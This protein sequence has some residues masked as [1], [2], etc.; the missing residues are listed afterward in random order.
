MIQSPQNKIYTKQKYTR[1]PKITK[2]SQIFPLSLKRRLAMM[3]AMSNISSRRLVFNGKQQVQI[4]SCE[5]PA[6]GPGEVL[7]RCQRSLM[8]TGTENI[9]FNRLFDPGT[10]WDNW[11][12]YPFYPGYAAA[13]IIDATG[14]GVS[15]LRPGDRVVCRAGHG[16]HAVLGAPDCYPVPEGISPDSAVWFALAKI[17]FHGAVAAGYRL[18]DSALVIGA[19]PIGQMSLRWAR[20][21]GARA[22]IVVDPV[23]DRR[24][25]SL[26]GGASAYFSV[27][28]NEAR[29]AVI[30]ANGDKL[31]EIVIDSTGHPAAFSAA[32]GLAASGGKVILLGDTGQP[33]KQALTGDVITKGLSVVGA[34]DARPI[35]GWDQ[36]SITAFFFR[37]ALDGRFSIEGLN[38]HVFSPDQCEEAYATANRD[39]AK[40]MGILF[41]WEA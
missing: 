5:L 29:D 28:A 35:P 6:P 31:P 17:A 30:A 23:P 34:H 21:S 37:L 20:A 7:V 25:I 36:A 18:G 14:E 16:A 15:S 33:G 40:T 8:S 26:A 11:V 39:R 22:V 13:G 38:S 12:K 24:E 10:H 1:Q 27:P 2:Y 19:G 41:R 3:A 9:V 4:E 32:L